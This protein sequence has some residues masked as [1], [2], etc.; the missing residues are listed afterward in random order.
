M[1][2]PAMGVVRLQRK[3]HCGPVNCIK[4]VSMAPISELASVKPVPYRLSRSGCDGAGS[5][6]NGHGFMRTGTEVRER[7]VGKNEGADTLKR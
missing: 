5:P 3:T 1:I 7:Q 4:V 6:S 2:A